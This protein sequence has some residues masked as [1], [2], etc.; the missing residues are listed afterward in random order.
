MPLHDWTRIAP[1]D[2]HDM[3]VSWIAT[4]RTRLN[5]GL[6]PDGYYAMAEHVVPPY[7]PDVLTLA[8][9]ERG[10][11]PQWPDGGDGGGGGV[12]VA[13]ETEVEVT[14]TAGPRKREKPPER[15][16][17]VRHAEGRRL[18]AVIEL[19]SPGN[20]AKATAIRGLVEK[21]AALL[22]NGIHLS[23]IDVFPNPPRLP[24]G[25]GGAI[26]RSIRGAEAEYA[27]KFSRTHAAFA[28]RD[29]GGCVAQ[30]QSS[31]VGSPLPRLPL[32][33]TERGC[34][35]LPLEE[36]YQAAWAG[37]PKPLRPALE[38]PPA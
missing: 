18:V 28:A 9:G 7:A 24:R 14:L 12:A 30:F 13:T 2:F 27:P 37:Y 34:I 20:K 19:V 11:Q 33:L 23:I 8:T 1:N 22:A 21:S 36:T 6:L 15:H 17:T 10:A 26:W 4:I 16:I 3:H 31:E 5:T 25:F 32:Y 29:G 35:L 38:A